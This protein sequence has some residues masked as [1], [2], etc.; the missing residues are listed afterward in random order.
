MKRSFVDSRIEA[1][2]AACA[3]HGQALP[4]G[5]GGMPPKAVRAEPGRQR[6]AGPQPH[7]ARA[8]V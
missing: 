8:A 2:L 3:R 5:R 6:N 1:M 7:Q 4:R